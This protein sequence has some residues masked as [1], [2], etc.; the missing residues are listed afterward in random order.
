MKLAQSR[1]TAQ[2]QISVPVEVR[3][4]L[5]LGPGALLEWDAEGDRVVV[6]RAGRY[7]SEDL[8]RVLFAREPRAR[9]LKEMDEGIR[10][11][12]RARH[13]RG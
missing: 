12:V 1:L 6:R 8:H 5:G 9:S 10:Q 13:A 3:R 4:R 7:G 11:A 2:G